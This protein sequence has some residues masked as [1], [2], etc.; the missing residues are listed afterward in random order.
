MT[1][2][3]LAAAVGL[4]AVLYTG[5]F[6]LVLTGRHGESLPL[7]ALVVAAGLLFTVT[8]AIAAARRPENRTG[9]QMLAVGL[10]WSLG[11]LQATRLVSPVHGRLRPERPF[12]R[13]RSRSLI[14]SY[15]TG[16]LRPRGPLDRLDGAR[17]S[18]PSAPLALS[19]FDATPIPTCEDC[20]ESAFLISD[21]PD[22]ARALAIVLGISGASIAGVVFVRLV[23]RYRQAT[24]PLRRVVGT[25]L[26]LHAR[27]TRGPDRE[28]PRRRRSAAVRRSSLELVALCS[29]AL[30][31]IAFLA[32]ILR[33][34]LARAGVA[35]LVIA[36]GD[37]TPLRDAL[38][39]AL[40]DPSL[41]L[42]YWSAQRQAWVDE[43][44]LTLGEPL[45]RGA[46]AATFIEIAGKRVAALIHDRSLADQRELVDAAA[47]TASIAFEKE[48]LQAEVRAQYRFLETIINTAPS[49]LSVV[50]T[51]GRIRN[52][53]RAVEVASG[54]DDRSLLEGRH[55]WDIFIDPDEREAMIQRF[56]DASPDFPAS[57]YEN[58]FTDARGH[59]RVIAWRSAP[60]LDEN[61]DVDPRHR[62]RDRHHRAEAAR[63][64]AAAPV[65]LREHRRRHDPEL[66]RDHRSRRGRRPARRQPRLP[67][68][69]RPHAGGPRGHLV[70]RPRGAA[71]TSSRRGWR[72]RARRT[73][74][75][76]RN[77]SRA[78]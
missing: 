36:I 43:E 17:R 23:H 65:E 2:S 42:V 8:G 10:L 64:R 29:A 19:L 54:L 41:D 22:L 68:R 55:F 48:R 15:P 76:R 28:Q 46:H 66:H 6:V 12:L 45:A 53:N 52:F 50:D 57:E 35:D 13:R 71:R 14:L 74:C 31:P 4:G 27:G 62:R 32:G 58:T 9:M 78:G 63:A 24:P 25:R 44:G 34:R 60:L 47:A 37:G 59:E 30:M 38:A 49:L 70:P 77:V 1:R 73:A 67:R 69:L 75:P 56:K 39:D 51:E 26:P 40:G 11:T 3:R 21:Q 20:P 72:S 7:F 33:S 18:S 61:G 5:A 16:R